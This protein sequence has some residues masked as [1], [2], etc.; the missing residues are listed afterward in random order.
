MKQQGPTGAYT[1][2]KQVKCVHLLR[3]ITI[4]QFVCMH[5][6]IY[7]YVGEVIPTSYLL[8]YIYP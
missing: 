5:A 8:L 4:I 1:T 6:C 2:Y 7:S 3:V